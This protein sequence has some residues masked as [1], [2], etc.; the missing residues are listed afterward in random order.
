[1]P[2]GGSCIFAD[3]DGFRAS[4]PGMLDLSVLQ[5]REFYARLTWVELPQLHPLRAREASPRVA[6]VALP[7]ENVYVSFPTQRDSTLTYDGAELRFGDIML[8]SRGERLHQR[9]AT[10]SRWGSISLTPASLMAFG[11]TITGRR[12]VPPPVSRFLRPLAADRLQLLR[13]HRQACRIAE[14]KLNLIGHPEVARA[15][16]QDLILGLANCLTNAD[17][18]DDPAVRYHQG[19]VLEPFETV[20]ATHPCRLLR[21]SEISRTI[22]VSEQVLRTC[23]SKVLGMSPGRYQRLRRLKLVRGELLRANPATVSIAEVTQRYGVADLPHFVTEFRNAYGET[24]AMTLRRAA[25]DEFY[26]TSSDFA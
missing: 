4:L 10:A 26:A 6:Y 19:R 2:A 9:T 7:S 21:T 12:L 16:E 5:P 14:T 3:A 18:R 22:G 24:P 20:L 1:M 11:R 17:P 8:H 25:T 15:L 13:L 23:C